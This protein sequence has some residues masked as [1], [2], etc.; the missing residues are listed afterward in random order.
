MDRAKRII[1][2]VNVAHLIDHMFV[3]IFFTAVLGMG[4]EFGRGYEEL[5]KLSIGGV[6]AFGACSIPAGWLGDRWSRRNMMAIFFFGIG[7]A[8][9]L[10]GLSTTSFGLAV[11]L[12]L[13]GIFAAIYH[14]VGG[15]MLAANAKEIGKT[16]GFNGVWGNVGVAVAA[17]ITGALTTRYGWRMAF[18]LPGVVSIIA[19]VIFMLMVPDERVAAGKKGG[20][21]AIAIPTSLMW[22]VFLVLALVLPT[23]SIVFQGTTQSLPKLFDERLDGLADSAE[24]IGRFAFFAFLFGASA[25]VIVGHLIDRLPMK[26]VFI[27]VSIIQAPAL[28]ASALTTG[29]LSVLFGGLVMF[30]VFGKVTVNDTMIARYTADAWRARAYSLRYAVSLSAGA[31]AVPLISYLYGSSGNFTSTFLIFAVFGACVFIGAIFFPGASAV[32]RATAVPARA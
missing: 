23:G 2:F 16:L 1:A 13:I 25:Q 6:I 5:I 19:G 7:V 21:A 14:P 27:A 4:T 9:I 12:T 18:I 20:G 28:L 3:L 24:L 10:A 17:L 29:W 30:G 8:A 22:R 15:A 11:T 32:E 26:T 31:L